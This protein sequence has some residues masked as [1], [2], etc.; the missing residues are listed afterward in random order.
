MPPFQLVDQ[1]GRPFDAAS[2][3]GKVTVLAAFHTTCQTTCPLYTGL[4]FQL[5]KRLPASVQL[6]EATTDP[7]QDTRH[8]P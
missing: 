1:A 5:R 3:R 8:E 7:E 2:V 6:V 4:F